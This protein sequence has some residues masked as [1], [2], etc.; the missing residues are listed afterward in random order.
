MNEYQS[1][2][3]HEPQAPVS[4]AR[5]RR[6][7]RALVP[8]DAQGRAAFLA[9]LSRRA[10][11]SYELFVYALLCGSILGAGYIL[12]SQAVLIFGILMAPLMTP[13]VGMTLAAVSGSA[14]FFFQTL[15]ALLIAAL[16][17]F[18]TGAL[19]GLASRIWQPLT[20]TQAFTLSHLWWPALVVLAL[21]AI[22]LTVSFIRSED[23]PFLPSVM[24][25]YGLF[26]PL[27]AGGFGL[28]S[29]VGDIW[30]HGLLVFFVHLAWTSLF[31]IITLIILR[32]R[33]LTALG[34]PFSILVVV[35][36]LILLG[37]LTGWRQ[38]AW[39]QL[40][41]QPDP[42]VPATVEV[43]PALPQAPAPSPS[44]TAT[45]LAT[46][47]PFAAATRTRTPEPSETPNLTALASLTLPVTETATITPTP[48]ATPVYARIQSGQGG[49]AFIRKEPGG[50][51]LATLDNGAYVI[52]L[53]DRQEHDGI[54]W[55]HV[56]ATVNDV[57]FDGWI[58]Q[59]V[60][61]T[62]TPLPGW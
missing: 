14:R 59:S 21:G 7:R 40:T 8:R 55:I 57:D 45:L 24:L 39:A 58:I 61:M 15:A 6:A 29:G 3:S 26:L 9:D 25:A 1:P 16:L 46:Q 44:A 33:P 11:P 5:R 54:P 49:G 42:L 19:A 36:L 32:F 43:Q 10:Y 47:T 27:S 37:E 12:D 17:V 28:G 48:E 22:V 31:G 60:L 62:A 41:G 52:V 53:P 35:G 2:P 56:L 34:Y 23:K 51:V 50:D 38:A 30:P 20:L 13:W 4:R 18:A